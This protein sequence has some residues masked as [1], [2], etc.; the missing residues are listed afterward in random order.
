[1]A[2][3]YRLADLVLI[4]IKAILAKSLAQILFL[5]EVTKAQQAKE[6]VLREVLIKTTEQ[7]SGE[8]LTFPQQPDMKNP[9]VAVF[10]RKNDNCCNFESKDGKIGA[11]LKI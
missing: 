3:N 6:T 5:P 8:N 4:E 1:M 7:G 11:H 9:I 2:N 10:E